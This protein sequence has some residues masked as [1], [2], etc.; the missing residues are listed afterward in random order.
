MTL[1]IDSLSLEQREPWQL[2]NDLGA[3]S[4]KR[5]AKEFRAA[6]HPRYVGRDMSGDAPH[7]REM[8]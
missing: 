4:L 5:N 7:D 6:I 8:D 2:V 3:L 1:D